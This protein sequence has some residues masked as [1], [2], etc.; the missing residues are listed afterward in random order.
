[1]PIDVA[2]DV[3]AQLAATGQA[4][5]GWLGVVGEDAIDRQGGG[6]RVSTVV[7][8]SPAASPIDLL[9]TPAVLPNDVIMAVG[10]TDVASR[11]DLV[12]ALR[13][14][15]PQ[16]PVELTVIRNDKI[17]KVQVPALGTSQALAAD[18]AIVA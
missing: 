8:G 10:D 13:A 12:A 15:R 2:R 18:L 6:V 3:A 14:L 4:V 16:D 1:V 5:H 9:G 17:R 7:A 11:G